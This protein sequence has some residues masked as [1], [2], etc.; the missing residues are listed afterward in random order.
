MPKGAWQCTQT[1]GMQASEVQSHLGYGSLVVFDL[2]I[3][4][5]CHDTH[6]SHAPKPLTL[7]VTLSL[8]FACVSMCVRLCM[9]RYVCVH[10]CVCM[11]VCVRVCVCVRESMLCAWVDVRV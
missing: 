9:G 7:Y 4:L 3:S 5:L 11:C 10:V 2:L 6:A 8:C 1:M